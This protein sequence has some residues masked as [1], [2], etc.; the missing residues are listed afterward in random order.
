MKSF[1]LDLQEPGFTFLAGQWVDL[2][3]PVQGMIEIG[4]YSITSSP[5]SKGWIELAVKA[6]GHNP[7]A[8]YLHNQARPGDSVEVDGGHGDFFLERG[9]ADSLVLIGGGIGVTPLMSMLR[10]VRDAAPEVTVAMIASA[11]TPSELLFR[12]DIEAIAGQRPRTRCLFSVTRTVDP[13]WKGHGGRIDCAFLQECGVDLEG[14]FYLC[15]PPG[16]PDA[17]AG[18]I[19]RLGVP[20]ARIRYE[21]WW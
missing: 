14:L 5:L 7:V 17:I 11:S 6:T 1:V 15:G 2:Y 3:A 13:S 21:Q 8:W 19:Q 4:G 9:M 20:A 18:E 16:M 10:Y 12:K